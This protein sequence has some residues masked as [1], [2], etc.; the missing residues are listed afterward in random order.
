MRPA[1]RKLDVAALGELAVAGIAVDLQDPLEAVEMGDRPLGL[2]V[3][4]ID[5]DDAR[6][7]GAT[8]WPVVSGI[9]QSCPVLV[10]PRPGSST[11]IVVS[12]ANSFDRCLSLTSRRSCSGRRCQ[13]ACPTQSASVE[14]S[15]SMPWRA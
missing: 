4:C 13:A 9:G 12:S 3:G 7:I 5:I 2:A 6:R 14:R 8:P 10:R 11:G 1:E 15:R